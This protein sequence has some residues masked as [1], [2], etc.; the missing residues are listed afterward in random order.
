MLSKFT[1]ESAENAEFSPCS[2]RPPRLNFLVDPI[3]T[4]VY[5]LTRTMSYSTSGPG[6]VP[7]RAFTA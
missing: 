6:V 1:A 5:G 7:K 4:T 2:P 3:Q